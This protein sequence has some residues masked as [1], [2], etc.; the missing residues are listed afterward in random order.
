MQSEQMTPWEVLLYEARLVEQQ[1]KTQADRSP[2]AAFWLGLCI[3]TGD[4]L[5]LTPIDDI[6]Q[7]MPMLKIVPIPHVKPWLLG[8]AMS[9]GEIFATTDLSGFLKNKATRLTKHTRILQ[10]PLDENNCGFLVDKVLGLHRMLLGEIQPALPEEYPLY[11]RYLLGKYVNKKMA[12][13]I[14]SLKLITADPQFNQAKEKFTRSSTL[15]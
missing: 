10:L 12:L 9:R 14:I 13:P 11:E 8:M 4:D 7:I 2:G 1:K 5:F 3:L 6:V 15:G